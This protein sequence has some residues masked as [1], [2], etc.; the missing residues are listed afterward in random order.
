MGIRPLS[1]LLTLPEFQPPPDLPDGDVPANDGTLADT[2]IPDRIDLPAQDDVS[3]HGD[4]EPNIAHPLPTPDHIRF[5]E[6]LALQLQTRFGM[7]K[8][9]VE[10]FLKSANW[11]LGPDGV[12]KPK[13]EE[14][15]CE[16]GECPV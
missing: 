13:Q 10:Y 14:L 7:P 15:P 5:F 4:M 6:L 9:G 2:G 16:E 11:A 8:D 12:I 3:V 1:E